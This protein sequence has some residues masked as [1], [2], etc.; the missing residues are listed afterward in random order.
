MSNDELTMLRSVP[1]IPPG[2][3]TIAS[4]RAEAAALGERYNVVTAQ[5]PDLVADADEMLPQLREDQPELR[6]RHYAVTEHMITRLELL[7]G[8]LA[9]AAAEGQRAGEVGK[10]KTDEAQK[11][12]DELLKIRARL[13]SI[14]RAAALP[15]DL[16]SLRLKKGGRLNVVMMRME[17]VLANVGACRARLP[18]GEV[19]DQ[20]VVSARTLLDGQ[21]EARADA[22]LAQAG[23]KALTAERARYAR[24]LLDVMTY[25]GAQ[26]MAAFPD[27]AVREPAYRLD[28]VYG[29]RP[30]TVAD[31]GAGGSEGDPTV[32]GPG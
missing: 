19:V 11:A 30:S 17:E 22:R 1:E 24:L 9:P 18:D 2:P 26:G 23:R 6:R 21:R 16:F 10:A 13:A 29:R 12:K 32:D 14:G 27:D 20:L 4:L 25:I 8:E 15:A 3:V 7:R 31:P 5:L 28:H